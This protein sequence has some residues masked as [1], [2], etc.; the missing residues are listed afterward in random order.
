M[1]YIYA[2]EHYL[3]IKKNEIM[4]SAEAWIDLEIITLSRV[5]QKKK[6]KYLVMSLT[7]GI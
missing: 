2:I 7:C 3:T 4:P 6:D 5:S 1:W